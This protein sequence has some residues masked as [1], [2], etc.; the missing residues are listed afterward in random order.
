MSLCVFA[1]F[2]DFVVRICFGF[3]FRISDFSL[4]AGYAF[5]P[6]RLLWPA[7]DENSFRGRRSC[8]IPQPLARLPATDLAYRAKRQVAYLARAGFSKC[9]CAIVG[10]F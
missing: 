6:A 9:R 8:A 10:R 2:S 4:G 1:N 3:G 7:E 5:I